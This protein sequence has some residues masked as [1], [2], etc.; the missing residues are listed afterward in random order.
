MPRVLADW[1]GRFGL[2][3]ALVTTACVA[4]CSDQQP[5]SRPMAGGGADSVAGSAGIGGADALG[6]LGGAGGMALPA[7]DVPVDFFIDIQPILNDYCVRCHGGVRELPLPPGTPLNLQSRERAVKVLGQPLLPDSAILWIR[8]NQEDPEFRM[9]LGQQ[10]LPADKLNKLR[11][12]LYQGAPWPQQWS[13]APVQDKPLTEVTVSDEAWVKT[14]VDRFVMHELDELAIKPSPEA[15]KTTLI[16]R[17]SLDLTGILPSVAELDTFLNDAAPTAYETVVD[18]LL[19]SPQFGERW[20]RHWHDLARYSD[21]DGYE[22]DRVRL[23][24][25]R[26]RDWV[27]DSFNQDQPFDQFTIEQL[28][29]DLLPNATPEQ[30][31]ATGFH[32]NTLV[33]REGGIDPEEDRSKRILDR[34]A[35]V[36]ETWL[37]LTLG[38]T[39]C[40]SHPYDDIKQQEFY[41]LVAFF[42][43]SDDSITGQ[44]TSDPNTDIGETFAVPTNAAGQNGTVNAYVLKQ[45]TLELRPNYLYVRG[46]FL[47][48]DK[49]TELLPGTPAVLPA[50]TPRGATPDRLD[51]GRWLVDVANPLTPR[52]AVNT[53]WYHLFGQGL[54]PS[55]DD[56]GARATYPSHP[57]LLDWLAADFVKN[58]WKR[59]RLIKEIVMSATY[60]QSAVTRADVTTDPQNVY[61]SRQNRVRVNAEIIADIN[62]SA[63]GLLSTRVGGPSAFPPL[64]PELRD[65]VRGAYG[66]FQ[67]PDTQ[68]EDRYRRGVYTFHKRLALYP[69]LDVFDW[70]SASVSTTGRTR[71][72]T[73]LQ[74]LATLHDVLFVEAAQG[75]ARRVQLEKPGNLN[76]QLVYGFRLATSRA[77][78]ADELAQLQALFTKEQTQYAADAAAATSIVGQFMPDGANPA[79]AAAWVVVASTILNLDEVLNRE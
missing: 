73:P 23:N 43:N 1:A 54:A 46:D 14:P 44:D 69:N 16:R 60:R 49:T 27:I 4:G 26:W 7:D 48:P 57:E 24:A 25:W 74:A 47:N 21:S 11:R 2:I 71:A 51:L 8:V 5:A 55:L 79:D 58:G 77:P 70:P 65:L 76:D 31:L 78:T 36:A 33:N 50:M 29:G 13:F 12:W 19:A 39:Q 40:H 17:V 37:G 53:I 34:A 35:T 3:L 68:G 10:A 20:G 15:D 6:G 52:V 72:N 38:C 45:R 75:L 63:A 28:G 42:N 9:P 30:V 18:R 22:K 67:W 66:N 62:L 32:R 41:K 56:F 64:P 59:K 61:L